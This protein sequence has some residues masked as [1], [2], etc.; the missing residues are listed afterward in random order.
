MSDSRRRTSQD[1]TEQQQ[2]PT[3]LITPLV[4][5]PLLLLTTT[6]TTA[7]QQQQQP[8]TTTT[9][10]LSSKTTRL[11]KSKLIQSNQ[12]N[13]AAQQALEGVWETLQ[14]ANQANDQLKISRNLDRQFGELHASAAPFKQDA[15][16]LIWP[17]CLTNK[18]VKTAFNSRSSPVYFAIRRANIAFVAEYVLYAMPGEEAYGKN[19]IV[20]ACEGFLPLV[21][22]PQ[23]VLEPQSWKLFNELKVQIYI[24]R[25]DQSGQEEAD[26]RVL[27][28]LFVESLSSY[29]GLEVPLESEIEFDKLATE[30]KE[31][32]IGAGA[33]L[34]L[35]QSRHPYGKFAIWALEFLHRC[36]SRVDEEAQEY[37]QLQQSRQN[38]STRRDPKARKR[39]RTGEEAGPRPSD[40]PHGLTSSSSSLPVPSTSLPPPPT[41][42]SPPSPSSAAALNGDINVGPVSEEEY[43]QEGGEHGSKGYNPYRLGRGKG[44]TSM[45]RRRWTQEE[46]ELLLE[47]VRLHSNKYDC[48]AQIMKRHG[49]GG[50]ISE[51]LKDQNNV[52]L[53][54]KARNL[55]MEWQRH[56]YPEDKP[57]L[58]EAF[59]RFSVK[60]MKRAHPRGRGSATGDPDGLGTTLGGEGDEEII[61]GGGEEQ[62]QEDDDRTPRHAKRP[63]P[64]LPV[65]NNPHHH[66]HHHPQLQE[67]D[68]SSHLEDIGVLPAFEFPSVDGFDPFDPSPDRSPRLNLD[69]S[70]SHLPTLSLDIPLQELDEFLL[71][72][73][74]NNTHHHSSCTTT[75]TATAAPVTIGC[76][77]EELAQIHP[78]L[79]STGPSSSSS[80]VTA[81]PGAALTPTSAPAFA[82][83]S[84]PIDAALEKALEK[85]LDK[86][87]D[88]A[89]H[90]QLDVRLDSG[91]HSGL[92]M[93]GLVDLAGLERISQPAQESPTT[94]LCETHVPTTLQSTATEHSLLALSSS[95]SHSLDHLVAQITA[96]SEL[97]PSSTNLPLPLPT[98]TS[99]GSSGSVTTITPVPGFSKPV[100]LPAINPVSGAL[101]A[102]P[103]GSADPDPD[104]DAG[105][106]QSG[107]GA[108]QLLLVDPAL[109]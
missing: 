71:L 31:E 97:L 16:A 102:R 88:S 69:D 20:F 92:E 33:D 10:T 87:F 29:S 107:I 28:N 79:A 47:E 86:A 12:L 78:L 66:H 96:S 72:N 50:E 3:D 106:P 14:I 2:Q 80:L 46:Y 70:S 68:G 99:S 65:T 91:L 85:A 8:S 93:T 52:S 58:K 95:S 84:Q 100:D 41:P 38:E 74:H 67:E 45:P 22:D 6:T 42:S 59:A 21:L 94:T 82:S 15:L 17:Q 73:S 19:D 90:S 36:A 51:V 108:H 25:L 30:T 77:A 62:E 4:V 1:L 24:Q 63:R 11:P 54:D 60:N 109:L 18:T 32:L 35:L 104:P 26:S 55:T 37:E 64:N 48:M 98:T 75:E 40:G 101:E 103:S 5:D 23:L 53:K 44:P 9:T 7:T 61:G 13:Q 49:K 105:E 76:T 57:W 27:P 34:E 89:F 83:S 39:G 81:P 43:P 56:G